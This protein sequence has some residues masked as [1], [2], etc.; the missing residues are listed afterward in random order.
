MNRENENN[1]LDKLAFMLELGQLVLFTADS[2]IE[3]KDLLCSE[4]NF[5]HE[6]HK[7]KITVEEVE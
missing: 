1:E 7:F 4:G 3:D 5:M 2:I 6:G